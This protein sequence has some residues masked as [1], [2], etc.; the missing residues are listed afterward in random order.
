[1]TRTLSRRQLNRATLARQ[2]L[3]ERSPM[4]ARPMIEHLVGLQAQEPRDPYVG[5][6]SRVVDFD[7]ADLEQLL[8]DRAV[9]RL[10]VQRGTVHAVTAEDARVLRPLAQPLLT[11]QLHTHR[12]YAPLLQ[13]VHLAPV[14][15]YAAKVLAKPHNTKDLRA[16]LAAEF[17]DLD[18]AALAFACRNQ[19]PFVQVP[20]R[21]LWSRSG[22]VVGTTLKAWTGRDVLKRPAVDDVMVR[23]LAAFGPATV[24]DAAT[25]SRY[26]GLREVFERLRPTLR[27]YADEDGREYFDLPDAPMPDEDVPAPV[28]FLPQYDNVFLS[29]KDRS[30]VVDPD[31]Q[32]GALWLEHRG[33]V[34]SLMFDGMLAGAWR[35]EQEKS[36]PAT[37]TVRM[38]R[39]LSRAHSNAVTAEAGNLLRFVAPGMSHDI[40]LSPPVKR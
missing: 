25:W 20:P 1:M 19:L 24:A 23:Y 6:W 2:H 14:M 39:R 17:P 29:H 36:G 21:G 38:A 11:Q 37:L 10:T 35:I 15:A 27:T 18:A 8:L 13:G 7:A 16:A 32:W 40:E 5:L 30:R 4:P 33:F 3:L 34:G 12:D 26:T 31:A 9:V 28:R 22:Q